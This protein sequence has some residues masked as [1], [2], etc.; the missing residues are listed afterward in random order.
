MECITVIRPSRMAHITETVYKNLGDQNG[1][2]HKV[3]NLNRKT[4]PQYTI[5]SL[6]RRAFRSAVF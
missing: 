1:N 3:S 2:P 4:H 5:E 6:P